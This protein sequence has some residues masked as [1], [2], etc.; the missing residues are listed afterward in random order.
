MVT[1]VKKRQLILVE[2]ESENG[3]LEVLVNNSHFDNNGMDRLPG[4]F[5]DVTEH[6]KEGTTELVTIINTTQDA[7]PMHFHLVQFQLV[8]RQAYHAENYWEK[9]KK[10]FKGGEYMAGYGPPLPYDSLNTDGAFGGNPAVSSYLTGPVIPAR[11]EEMGWKDTYQVYPGEITTFIIRYA[12]TDIPVTAPVK[13]LHF[14]FDPSKGPGYVWHCHIVDHE[15][16]EMM[17][18]DWIEPASFR[19]SQVAINAAGNVY[20]APAGMSNYKWHIPAGGTITSGGTTTDNKVTVTWTTLGEKLVTV[21]YSSIGGSTV[22]DLNVPSAFP[23]N[24]N[25]LPTLSGSATACSTSTGNIYTTEPGMSNYI[26]NVTGGTITSGGGSTSNSATITWNTAGPQ[27]VSVNYTNFNGFTASSP[28]VKNVTVN[29]VPAVA[30]AITGSAT[31]CAG[32]QGVSYSVGTI[33][34]AT[35]YNWTVP[36]G[37]TVASG[38]GTAN[39]TVNYSTG[40]VSGNVS[41]SGSNGCGN[42]TAANLAVTV[43]PLTAASGPISGPTAVC[44]G[45]AGLSFSVAPI[46]NATSYTWSLPAG[47]TIVSGANTRSI[48]VNL[49]M[50]TISGQISVYGS[51]SCGNG[52]VSPAF[53]LTVNMIPPNPVITAVGSTVMSSALSGNQWSYSATVDGLG[54]EISGATAQNY[55]PTQNGWYWSIV[56]LNGCFSSASNRLYR[57]KPGE[58]NL[59]TLYPVPNHGDFTVSITTPDDQQFTIM[60]YDQVGKKIFEVPGVR[61]NGQFQLPVSLSAVHTGTY[62]VVVRGNNGNV[63]KRFSIFK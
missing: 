41:V 9:Y 22:Y 55:T 8:S 23:V 18:P 31:V 43:N 35:S 17:R 45:S 25:A 14:G 50:S 6:P 40:A 54:A 13:D 2:H 3:P 10:S 26:W 51:N 16:N 53:A 42:G 57:L 37:A 7:H 34:N 36:T 20:T 30:G 44:Q 60:V 4:D 15:D 56:T 39:I 61:V 62:V 63:I 47:A 21:N 52:A 38:A 11:P 33:A 12:P 24:V 28:T 19:A 5:G 29:P 58:S 32:S 59:Y 46:A 27:T 49:S 48:V 1:P